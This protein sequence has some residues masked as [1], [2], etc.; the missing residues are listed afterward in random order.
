MLRGQPGAMRLEEAVAVLAHDVGH[1]EGWPG[2]RWCSRR[3]RRTVSGAGDRHGVQRV[4]D[5]LQVPPRQMQ[6]DHGVFEFDVP[7]QQLDRCAGRP[8]LQARCVAYECRRRCGET[9][10]SAGPA[11]RPRRQ[12]SHTT[13]GVIGLSARQFGDRAGKQ[14]RLRPHPAVVHAQRLQQ[15]SALS[16][17]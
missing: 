7:E 11:S 13:F 17:T 16:G 14:P 1:L 3:E 2:H 10:F 15:A 4:G 9:R 12:A 5:G 8:R 6:I